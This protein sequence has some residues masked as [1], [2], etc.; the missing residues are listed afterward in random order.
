MA[1]NSMN[2]VRP[3][4][5]AIVPVNSILSLPGAPLRTAVANLPLN[6]KPHLRPPRPANMLVNSSGRVPGAPFRFL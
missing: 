6:S 2:H 4:R 1:M 3:P 5:P